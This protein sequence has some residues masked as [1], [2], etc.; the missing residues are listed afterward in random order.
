M[1]KPTLRVST[2]GCVPA[3]GV[4]G[5]VR[6]KAGAELSSLNWPNDQHTGLVLEEVRGPRRP[7][8]QLMPQSPQLSV[9]AAPRPCLTG[10]L[11]FIR[12]QHSCYSTEDMVR[13]PFLPC[14]VTKLLM[15]S[16]PE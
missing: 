14:Y 6:K 13:T 3:R 12:V 5:V 10:R 11:S 2:G 15:I 8:T 1:Q 4:D 16:R 9:L 7:E